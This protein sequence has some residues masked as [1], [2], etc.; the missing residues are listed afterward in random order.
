MQVH[1]Y[2]EIIYENKPGIN[3]SHWPT[4]IYMFE[5]PALLKKG[6][7]VT[8]KAMLLEDDVCFYHNG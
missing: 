2:D 6:Q 3:E 7:I 5:E 8:V 1:L 4:P